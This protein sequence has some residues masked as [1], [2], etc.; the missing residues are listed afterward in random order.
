MTKS[1][2]Y[3]RLLSILL[4][5]AA[6]FSVS[7]RKLLDQPNVQLQGSGVFGNI[8]YT[9]QYLNNIYSNL[10]DPLSPMTATLYECA[11]DDARFGDATNPVVGLAT[12]SLNPTI[13]P[14]DH[15]GDYYT[16]VRK[17]NILLAN[18][19][20]LPS[21]DHGS[22]VVYNNETVAVL[23]PRIKGEAYYLR[24][25]FYFELFKRYGP[26][27]LV[28]K[29]LT[30]NDNSNLPRADFNTMVNQMSAD[31][32]SAAN[33][34]APTYMSTAGGGVNVPTYYGHATSWAARALK[35]RMLLYVASPLFNTSN[36][37]TKWQAA[38]NA[39]L[40]F[41]NGTAPFTLTAS[42]ANNFTGNTSG[43]AEVI[44]AKVA[45]N[46]NTMEALNYPVGFG[47]TGNGICPSQNLVDA[48]E[49]LN[50]KPISDPTSGYSAVSPYASRDSRLAAT[51]LYNG[52]VYNGRAIQTYSGG[53]VDGPDVQ[54]GSPTG[55][56]MKKLLAPNIV[57][58]GNTTTAQHNGIY[59]RLAEMLLNYAEALNEANS[60]PVADVY[61]AVNR[62][63]TRAGQPVLPAGLTQAQM[64][65]RIQ[66]ER[67]V[68]LCFEGHRYWDARRWNIA[69]AV[70]NGAL[71]GIKVTQNGTSFS[72]TPYVV[73]QHVFLPKMNLYPIPINQLQIN[74]SLTQTSGW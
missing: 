46:N 9:S 41:F 7:C 52:A 70:F 69:S 37:A 27:P 3:K 54:G 60:S 38:A 8:I 67:R 61:T 74:A 2:N 63:R 31:C 1:L 17:C 30:L 44:L 24:A 21:L 42:Y 58:V 32:D 43:N 51:I 5:G 20:S 53:G 10:P 16:A 29:T 11:T 55:Y 68:E 23:K 66:N 12:G 6:L 25:F 4:I 62:V 13:N 18:I 71:N 72:Y 49:M 34:L 40:P 56:Y 19:D 26:V 14:D 15:F 57:L 33:L 45:V 35:A 59:F 65:A 48:F 64:R 39:A 22:N 36:D 50:G 73:E 28:L 47:A